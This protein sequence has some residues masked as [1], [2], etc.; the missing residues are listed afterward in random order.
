MDT[1]DLLWR[2][3]VPSNKR[4]RPPKYSPDDVVDAAIAVADRTGSSFS[5]RDVAAQLGTPVM[6]L[7]SYVESREQLLELMAD[8]VRAEM[9]LSS[10]AGD[11]RSSLVAIADDNLALFRAHP[12]LADLESER[13][14]LGPGTLAKYEHELEAVE[15]FDLDDVEKDAILTLL[16]DFA[17]ASAR[18]QN[19][20]RQERA[21]E[22][23]QEWWEREGAKLA[24]LGIEARFPLAS[25]VGAAAGEAQ[26]AANNADTAYRFGLQTILDGVAARLAATATTTADEE[27]RH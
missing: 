2:N 23:P 1:I 26:G 7:Y 20:A 27:G 4:G 21:E 16:H 10:P 12:W 18:A 22:D 15:A 24:V 9:A 17:R 19:H 5:L 25:R 6:S 14:T 11:W 3:E 8:V 13:A